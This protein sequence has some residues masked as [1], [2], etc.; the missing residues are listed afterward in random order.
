MVDSFV[1]YVC[2]VC[3]RVTKQAPGL[4]VFCRRV[5]WVPVHSE[6]MKARRD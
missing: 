1:T 2:P 3:G 6:R 4:D 5:D